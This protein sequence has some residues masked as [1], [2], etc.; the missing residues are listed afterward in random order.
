MTPITDRLLSHY[1][2]PID[3]TR[4]S[5]TE[6]GLGAG[7]HIFRFLPGI[8]DHIPDFRDSALLADGG[9]TSL[10]MYDFKGA[11]EIYRNFLSWLYKTFDVEE[12]EFRADLIGR[13]KLVPGSRVLITG[14]GIGDD[15]VEVLGSLDSTA[16]VFASD[17]A[18]EMVVATRAALIEMNRPASAAVSLSV[19]NACHLPFEDGF[20][21][22]AFHFGGINLFDD[23][24]LAIEEMARVTRDGGRVVFGDEGIAPWLAKTEYGRMAVANNYLWA[25][26]APIDVLP[27]S[28]VEV[29][30]SWVLGNCFYVIEFE[31]R[32]QG[33]F[34]NPDVPHVGRRGGSMR[35]RYF[36]Q[37]EGVSVELRQK[38][39]KEAASKNVSVTDWLE[40]AIK[41]AL[42]G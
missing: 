7:D 10:E 29:S 16:S 42:D 24:R 12:G 13:L 6:A 15:V 37:L 26:E 4:L 41:H 39:L 2:S 19:C 18:P 17:L 21:D 34:M 32:S 8:D 20:F 3:R 27:Q 38:V 14:C 25:A 22:A 23:V 30:L 35:T 1:V 40:S 28:A 33:P 11:S 36:G 31:K 9:K 5:K